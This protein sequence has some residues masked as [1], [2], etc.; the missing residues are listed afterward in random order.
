MKDHATLYARGLVAKCGIKNPL[1]REYA[2]RILRYM[3]TKPKCDVPNIDVLP[4]LLKMQPKH[5]E[6][7]IRKLVGN[8]IIT[9]YEY[10]ETAHAPRRGDSPSNC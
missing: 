5:F 6:L 4:K 1:V 2:A 3:L 9:V 7:A 8:D 10:E